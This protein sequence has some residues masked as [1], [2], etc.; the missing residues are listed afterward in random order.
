MTCLISFRENHFLHFLPAL[1]MVCVVGQVFS[2]LSLHTHTI[3][4]DLPPFFLVGI[5]TQPSNTF[6]E[7]NALVHVYDELVSVFSTTSGVILGDMNADC[8]YLSQMKYETLDLVTDPRF[9]WLIDSTVDTTTSATDCSYDR[10][11]RVKS[12]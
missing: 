11:I 6:D 2:F 10:Y 1:I 3:S 8:T 9:V 4:A 5:H 7:M 12:C